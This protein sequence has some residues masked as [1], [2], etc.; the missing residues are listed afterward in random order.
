MRR[1]LQVGQVYLACLGV[2]ESLR[3]RLRGFQVVQVYQ[4]ILAGHPLQV[5]HWVL[6]VRV[7]QRVLQ[8]R[9][10]QDCQAYQAGLEVQPVRVFPCQFQAFQ[11]DRVVQVWTFLE[12]RVDLVVLVC[13]S[14]KIRDRYFF[15]W[16]W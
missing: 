7:V 10:F 1:E 11:V 2:L 15:D 5:D 13:S 12:V 4:G 9:V 14:D 8:V 3:F 6:S 16:S